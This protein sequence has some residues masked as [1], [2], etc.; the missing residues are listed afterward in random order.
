[1]KYELTTTPEGHVLHITNSDGFDK[2]MGWQ[3]GKHPGSTARDIDYHAEQNKMKIATEGLEES[4][5]IL[6]IK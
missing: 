6:E 1:M 2:K 3:T 4:V 5:A